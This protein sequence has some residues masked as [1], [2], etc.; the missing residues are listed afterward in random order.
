MHCAHMP[1]VA[2]RSM[3]SIQLRQLKTATWATLGSAVPWDTL[4]LVRV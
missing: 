4:A 2:V 3:Q 1:L